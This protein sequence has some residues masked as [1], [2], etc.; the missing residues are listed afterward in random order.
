MWLWRLTSLI[1]CHLQADVPGRLGVEFS[2]SLK[3]WEPGR[4]L[5]WVLECEGPRARSS[6]IQ[7]QEKMG[8]PAQEERKNS[9]F[10]CLFVPFAPVMNWMMPSTLV[11]MDLFTQSTKP[12]A[13]LYQKHLIDPPRNDISP[14]I[15]APLHP[16]KLTHK[17][18]HHESTSYQLGTHMHLLQ[19]NFQVRT[20][21]GS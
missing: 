2:L 16:V 4:L 8:V 11:R 15:W 17:T 18:G 10:L 5:L 12:N 13:S 19:L 1:I 14:A 21:T 3:A 7:G 20:V 9:P 6:N